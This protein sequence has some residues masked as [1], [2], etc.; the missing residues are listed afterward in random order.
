MV[1]R[2]HHLFLV[3]IEQF[4]H[5]LRGAVTGQAVDIMPDGSVEGAQGLVQRFKV[6]RHLPQH[7]LV[8]A[9][10]LPDAAQ[11]LPRLVQL[12][13][14]GNHPGVQDLFQRFQQRRDLRHK[15]KGRLPLVAAGLLFQP[16]GAA[17]PQQKAHRQRVGVA[18]GLLVLIARAVGIQRQRLCQRGKIILGAGDGLGAGNAV[19]CRMAALLPE[20]EQQLRIKCPVRPRQR[21]EQPR[22]DQFKQLHGNVL[23]CVRSDTLLLYHKAAGF[24]TKP[25]ELP[26]G[27]AGQTPSVKPCGF[28]TSLSE[29]G[30]PL[31]HALRRD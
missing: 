13:G 25:L 23:S 21:A 26:P 15:G 10:F 24:V 20:Q 8:G 3:L 5:L 28:A 4:Q 9:F 1:R 14:V 16:A 27:G 19:I 29:G 6:C 2:R 7:V 12:A 22:A 30:N 31:S 18:G 17:Q 11:Q